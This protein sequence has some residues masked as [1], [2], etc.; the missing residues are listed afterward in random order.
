MCGDQFRV[1]LLCDAKP[2]VVLSCKS[3]SRSIEVIQSEVCDCLLD[4]QC[5]YE[6]PR[7][8]SPT[9]S[10]VVQGFRF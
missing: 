10:L 3:I 8:Y 7:P 5:V 2:Q 9:L 1:E 6:A 4:A